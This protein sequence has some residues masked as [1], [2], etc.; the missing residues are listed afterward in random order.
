MQAGLLK[1]I[2]E[3][4]KPTIE[5]NEFGEQTQLFEKHVETKAQVIYD[6]GNRNISNNEI[7]FNYNI[8]FKTRYYIDVNE[9]MKVVFN[10]KK[11]RIISI[12]SDNHIQVKTII[13]EVINE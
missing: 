4:H 5:T 3:I 8:T 9:S 6:R 12:E 2:I 11:Y 7:V 13:C 10:K 1:D